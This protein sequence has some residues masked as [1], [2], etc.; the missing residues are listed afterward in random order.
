LR[1]I[2]RGLEFRA[3]QGRGPLAQ[4]VEQL[5]LN[6]SQ[7]VTEAQT[8][9][10]EP[11]ISTTG[12]VALGTSLRQSMHTSCTENSLERLFRN[13]MFHSNSLCIKAFFSRVLKLCTSP[14]QGDGNGTVLKVPLVRT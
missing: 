3:K 12:L 7:T 2:I 6:Q 4:L 8:L 1:S 5:T 10:K 14:R 11:G 13:Q 9:L